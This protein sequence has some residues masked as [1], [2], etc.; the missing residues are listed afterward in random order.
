MN[1]GLIEKYKPI[2][3]NEVVKG[4]ATLIGM[5]HGIDEDCIP[6]MIDVLEDMGYSDFLI[7]NSHN[8]VLEDKVFEDLVNT[9]IKLHKIRDELFQRVGEDTMNEL[10]KVIA[11]KTGMWWE[12]HGEEFSER[13]QNLYQER[14]DNLK[15]GV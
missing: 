13:M 9:S 4:Q 14:I 10:E 15:G 1:Q 3:Q 2:F 12:N 8:L 11:A 7:N 5:S 6:D